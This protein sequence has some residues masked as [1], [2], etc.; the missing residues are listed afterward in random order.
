LAIIIEPFKI[1][2]YWITKWEELM[3]KFYAGIG[4]CETPPDILQLMGE[5]A[6]KLA[7]S[8]WRLRSGGAQGADTAFQQGVEN[9]CR[10]Q[11]FLPQDFQ[12]IYLPWNGFNNLKE[13][14]SSGYIVYHDY[15][16][17]RLAMKYH[18]IYDRLSGKQRQLMARNGYQ[19]L[20]KD[21]QTP[22]TFIVCWT[23][24]GSVGKT[25]RGTGG[26]GQAIRIAFAHNIPIFNLQMTAH[27]QRLLDYVDMSPF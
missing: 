7:G 16:A 1:K 6:E 12:E 24:D 23:R 15:H 17:D 21:L 22:S 27:L 9:Y 3:N 10:K 18:P 26:T 5:I 4:S 20:G 13:D 8:G 14:K 2:V 11:V 19:V 25:S